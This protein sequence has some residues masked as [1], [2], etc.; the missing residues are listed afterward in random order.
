MI[1][2]PAPPYDVSIVGRAQQDILALLRRSKT[3][4]LHAEVERLL[5]RVESE[6][7]FRPRE[8]GDPLR[9]F[10]D[11]QTVQFRG[12]AAYVLAYYSVHERLP[13]VILTSVSAPQGHPLSSPDG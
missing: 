2:D 7:R 1:P 6:L 11:A 9:N 8:W 12:K 13:L 10:R 5:Y 4:G 3:H